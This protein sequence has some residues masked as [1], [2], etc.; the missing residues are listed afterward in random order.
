MKCLHVL[1]VL[2]AVVVGVLHYHA[3]FSTV[4][5]SVGDIPA[6]HI[7]F[8]TH[9]GHYKDID[10]AMNP[11]IEKLRGQGIAQEDLLLFGTYFTDPSSRPTEEWESIGGVI[12]TEEQAKTVPLHLFNSMKVPAMKGGYVTSFPYVSPLSIYLSV[13]KVYGALGAYCEGKDEDTHAEVMEVYDHT[14]G[15]TFFYVY[16]RE[17]HASRV[18]EGFEGS[19]PSK[20]ASETKPAAAA[21]TP[22]KETATREE[23]VVEKKIEEEKVEE[24]KKTPEGPEELVEH[25]IS[26]NKVVVFSK[27]YCPY[28]KRAIGTLEQLQAGAVVIQLDQRGDG[29]AIQA[30]LHKKTGRR[31]VPNVF[32][33]GRTIGGGDDT[34]A[35][36]QSGKLKELIANA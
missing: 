28:C 20:P 29:S 27:S 11:V 21:A 14:V 26:T 17:G 19:V 8:E 24:K 33:G 1:V 2:V 30:Y 12:L 9:R 6:R 16:P 23:K 15:K 7:V 35:L 18:P 36:A 10:Q 3:A 4:E 31:T 34:A 25:L 32:V 5:W 22:K 13:I